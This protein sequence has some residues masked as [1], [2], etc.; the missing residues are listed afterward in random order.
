MSGDL[1][2]ARHEHHHHQRQP[3]YVCTGTQTN[4]LIL[5][6]IEVIGRQCGNLTNSQHLDIDEGGQSPSVLLL[7][8]FGCPNPDPFAPVNYSGVTYGN[9]FI[10]PLRWPFQQEPGY[11]HIP[12]LIMGIIFVKSACTVF[13]QSN[14]FTLNCC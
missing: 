5:V 7:L 14:K 1:S 9:S 8:L 4:T 13:L 10:I 6:P 12:T 11:L 3:H 2:W